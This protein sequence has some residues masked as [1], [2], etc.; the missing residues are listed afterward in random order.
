MH[1]QEAGERG[2]RYLIGPQRVGWVNT[3]R[4]SRGHVCREH[5][6]HGQCTP[7]SRE[8]RRVSRRDTEKERPNPLVRCHRA[9]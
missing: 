1:T 9:G 5:S 3:R 6:G 8:S 2:R 4:S 7:D